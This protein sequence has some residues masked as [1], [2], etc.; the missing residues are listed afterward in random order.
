MTE[1]FEQY[2]SDYDRVQPVKI[3][4]YDF[5]H[6]L[7][8]DLVP[9][10][11]D[12]P[13][14]FADLGC[15]TGNFLSMLLERFAV[16]DGFALDLSEAMIDL[17]S[18]KIGDSSD[19]VQFVQHDLGD[20]L[21]V[22]LA[23]LDM[24]VAFSVLHHLTDERKRAICGEIFSALKPGGWLLLVDAMY[25]PYSSDVWDRGRERERSARAQ[26][27]E[28][29]GILQAELDRHEH[30]KSA[31][32]ESSPE[33]DRISTLDEQMQ[34]LRDAGFSSIDRVWHFWMEHLV[35]ARK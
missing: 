22:E 34:N 21:P 24:V 9:F 13:F 28:E 29:A 19:R 16:S 31:L 2:A 25:A 10:D 8:L 18:E 30:A 6:R 1:Y 5:Y 20:P 14:R 7:A 3:E 27:F 15:G 11:T 23:E 32:D 35:V 33:R 26:R 12:E 4:M 17:A